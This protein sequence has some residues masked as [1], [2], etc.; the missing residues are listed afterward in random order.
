MILKLDN[1]KGLISERLF[2]KIIN[3]YGDV[4]C[5]LDITIDNNIKP[6]LDLFQIFPSIRIADSFNF[7]IFIRLKF[8]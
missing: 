7:D 4:N 5:Q 6:C 2:S 3:I 1:Y 8:F